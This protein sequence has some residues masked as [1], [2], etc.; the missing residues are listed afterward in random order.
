M[1]LFVDLKSA[2][3]SVDRRKLF[4]CL[5]GRE[6]RGG[7]VRRCKVVLSEMASKV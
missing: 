1:L 4:E 2:L 5:R 3:D 6:I 7:L